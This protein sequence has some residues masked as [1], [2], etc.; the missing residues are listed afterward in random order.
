GAAPILS[1]D[2]PGGAERGLSV[3]DPNPGTKA[4]NL[5]SSSGRTTTRQ[6]PTPSAELAA[7]IAR[8]RNDSPPSSRSSFER[9]MRVENPLAMT[10]AAIKESEG[11]RGNAC[12]FGPQDRLRP[13]VGD[14]FAQLG[15]HFGH[16]W[17]LVAPFPRAGR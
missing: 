15:A 16:R 14:L 7:R 5:S 4:T 9:P 17:E 2:V 13:L 10:T 6:R 12:A 11:S 3:A 1:T 8:A